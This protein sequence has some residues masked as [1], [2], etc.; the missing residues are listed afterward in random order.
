MYRSKSFKKRIGLSRLCPKNLSI[1]YLFNQGEATEELPIFLYN[2]SS[3]EKYKGRI[4]AE[5][6]FGH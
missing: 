3:K 5:R 2:S 6:P 4:N 1:G